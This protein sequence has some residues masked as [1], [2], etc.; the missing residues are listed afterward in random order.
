LLSKGE[1]M[2]RSRLLVAILAVSLMYS[3]L[4]VA[5]SRRTLTPQASSRTLTLT[6]P[7]YDESEDDSV[8][9]DSVAA[10]S[11]A[12]PAAKV[13]KAA[14]LA[15]QK[16]LRI[17]TDASVDDSF[18][19]STVASDAP[20]Y[21]SIPK[22][23]AAINN[24]LLAINVRESRVDDAMRDYIG[25]YILAIALES[26]EQIPAV[27][28]AVNNGLVNDNTRL[29]DYQ[30]AQYALEVYISALKGCAKDLKAALGG[31]FTG[32]IAKNLTTLVTAFNDAKVQV[33]NAIQ[34]GQAAQSKAPAAAAPAAVPA[35][36]SMFGG[37]FSKK[38]P[39]AT[40]AATPAAK[41]AAAKPA[42]AKQGG[43]MSKLFGSK[44]PLTATPPAA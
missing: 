39:A 5:A 30:D 4:C 34:T 10:D 29:S 36:K 2:I 1:V 25:K 11:V 7:A 18:E 15:R 21:S 33:D 31:G 12:A 22:N 38:T 40:A 26:P 19:L 24:S 44:K 8:E 23:S 6:P 37:L 14:G 20:V 35:K 41:P 16:G 3:G 27:V 42:A 28:E 17:N 32:A 13:T 43:F 9:A